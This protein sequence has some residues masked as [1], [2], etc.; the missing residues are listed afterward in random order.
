MWR[1]AAENGARENLN[2]ISRARQLARL[3]M[4]LYREMGH[5]FA[6]YRIPYGECDQIYFAQ[7]ADGETYPFPPGT[8]DRLIA[9]M[10]VKSHVQLRQYR[11]LLRVPPEVW[12]QAD[13][14]NWPEAR[15]RPYTAVKADKGVTSVTPTKAPTLKLT[16]DLVP[17][18]AKVVEMVQQ[19]QGATTPQNI[20]QRMIECYLK[21]G[22]QVEQDWRR[23]RGAK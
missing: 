16:S 4:E 2:A 20:L 19:Q 14:E 13:D 10:G 9:F 15:L 5:D 1:Q 23:E 22:G 3:I 18:W 7:V 12:V 8:K 21:F 11:A 6:P 17:K